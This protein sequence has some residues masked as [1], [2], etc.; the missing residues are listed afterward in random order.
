MVNVAFLFPGQGSQFVGMGKGFYDS[1]AGCRALFE[2][3]GEILGDDIANL[4]FNGPEETLKL[5]ENTQPA[6]LIHSIIALKALRENGIDSVLAAGHSLG[7]YSALVSAGSLQFKD[8]VH[9]VR[10]RAIE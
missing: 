6:L 3:A 5:T 8:A 2:E 7:E 1:H 9:L 10:K 4:C